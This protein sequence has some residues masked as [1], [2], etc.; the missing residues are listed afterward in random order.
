M[1]MKRKLSGTE[2]KI[3]QGL[4]KVIDTVHPY[5]PARVKKFGSEPGMT[6][7]D[8]GCGPGRYAVEFAK[9]VGSKGSVIAVDVL[10]IALKA[11]EK[12]LKKHELTNVDLRLAREYDSGIAKGVADIVCAI[13]M[14][15]HVEPAPFLA[16]VRRIL[17]PEGRLL[18]AG[19]HQ[20][21][22][23]IKKAVEASGSWA[24]VDEARMFLRYVK[25]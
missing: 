7:V 6:V 25:K 18:I 11:T 20:T 21:R 23:S 16:E 22:K 24:L 1:F 3:M 8:Y 12:R 13:D 10:E 19:G 2:F 14:F 5:V 9:L 15:H 17:K 4:M